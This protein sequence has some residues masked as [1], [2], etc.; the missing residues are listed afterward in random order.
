MSVQ[1]LPR[2]WHVLTVLCLNAGIDRTY[3]VDGFEAGAYHRPQRVRVHAGGKGINVARVAHRLGVE[4][5]VSGFAGGAGG[6]FISQNLQREGVIADFVPIEEEPR[7]CINVV[8][9]TGKSQTRVDETG[10]L[11]TPSELQKLRGKW[12]ELLGKSRCAVLSGSAPRGMPRT[13]YAELIAAA[14]EAG[15]PAILDARDEL[16]AEGVKS[17]P[18]MVKPNLEEMSTLRGRTLQNPQQAL[19]AAEELTNRGMSIVLVSMGGAGA[20]AATRKQGSWIVTPPK[21]E[22]VNTVGCGDAMVAGFVAASLGGKGIA[23]C[24]RW[25]VAAGAANAAVFGNAGVTKGKLAE[26]LPQVKVNRLDELTMADAISH[27]PADSSE[28]RGQPQA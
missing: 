23:D 18:L 6:A 5:I 3:E 12:K 8:N 2:G 21:V 11:V 10:P 25:G 16:L 1:R 19:A 27:P 4:T 22:V 28:E 26:L 13:I 24:L 9:R 14:R 20:V 15:V 7:V 17:L